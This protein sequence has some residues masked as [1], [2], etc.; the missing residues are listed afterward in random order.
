LRRAELVQKLLALCGVNLAGR[1]N[2]KDMRVF[3]TL[4]GFDGNEE[5]WASEFKTLCSDHGGNAALGADPALFA[6]LIDDA[7]DAGCYCEESELK[8]MISKL[9][10]KGRTVAKP[11]TSSSP[12]SL[13]PV[14]AARQELIDNVF[15]SCDRDGNGALSS[16][17]LRRFAIL[18][19]FAG[20]DSAWAQEFSVLCSQY[21]G[22]ESVVDLALFTRLVQDESDDG[23]H[24]T[25]DELRDMLKNLRETLVT[26]A[27]SV[28]DL[29][30]DGCLNAQE[31]RCFAGHTG[32]D[33]TEADWANEYS[34]LC[35]SYNGLQSSI[36]L[37][38]FQKLVDDETDDGCYCSNVELRDMLSAMRPPVHVLPTVSQARGSEVQ[39]RPKLILEVFQAFD[40]DGDGSLDSQE[41]RRF[42]GHTGFDGDD[43]AW[44]FEYETLCSSYHG[45]QSTSITLAL[46]EKLVDDETDDGCFTTDQELRDML[47]A[48]RAAAPQEV[49]K[50]G[51]TPA[52][53]VAARSNEVQEAAVSE[54]PREGLVEKVFH[55]F[56]CDRD[57]FLSETEMRVFAGH[58]GFEGAPAEWADEY[59]MLC[60][61]YSGRQSAISLALF[62]KL[63]DD[64][65][66]DGCYCTDDELRD[67]LSSQQSQEVGDDDGFCVEPPPLNVS[68]PGC[69][70]D[71][72]AVVSKVDQSRAGLVLAVFEAFDADCDGVLNAQEMRRFAGYTGFDGNDA[73]WENEY[74]MLCS[75]YDGAQSAITVMLFARLVDD[76]TDDGCYCS[77]EELRAMLAGVAA[78][79]PPRAQDVWND[80]V[81]AE[82]KPDWSLGPADDI[83]LPSTARAVLVRNVFRAF[84]VDADAVLNA[85][86]MRKF[87]V[88]TGF[89]GN[90]EEW[91]QEYRMLCSTY[92]GQNSSITLP[93]FQKL[94]DDETDDGCYCEDG[95]LSDMLAA[96]QKQAA[97]SSQQIQARHEV[98]TAVFH[99]FDADC[100]GY[101]NTD[102][103]KRFAIYTDFNATGDE[104]HSAYRRLM[105][106]HG[107]Q[108]LNAAPD[109]FERLVDTCTSLLYCT[110]H[111]SREHWNL[112]KGH[113][114][115]KLKEDQ[116]RQ[117][118]SYLCRISRI[119]QDQQNRM[120]SHEESLCAQFSNYAMLMA[121]VF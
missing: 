98:I 10:A 56:D 91:T 113:V 101:L 80:V 60:S 47:S 35:S 18:T 100:D 24:C 97:G 40:T 86:E 104:W 77:D 74:T 2:Q 83:G 90:D 38:L 62:K 4:T 12:S 52:Q 78:E 87:A 102:E 25:D 36:S 51:V 64:D 1:L 58:T 68:A 13:A 85:Y 11:P 108:G 7:S 88:H 39:T 66:D 120:C 95:E 105:S 70:G 94:V 19:G 59:R 107:G 16:P 32:F 114:C 23:C 71:S 42:A 6:T 93:L 103:M 53:P 41:M 82:S 8:D 69:T 119:M 55:G 33:G 121:T 15:N 37:A 5:A 109:V 110:D 72:A 20:D 84:D 50:V 76:G 30:A 92:D 79:Q 73:D 63:V 27:F 106:T 57:G 112:S 96:Q 46:F 89:D 111:S 81:V 9:E 115:C 31:M 48:V 118:L 26:D 29:D 49:K 14:A 65:T 17:E 54:N 34:M 22:V 99:V 116:L 75:S 3:A 28:F 67:M 43:A 44:A 45:V 117:R 61:S 21:A